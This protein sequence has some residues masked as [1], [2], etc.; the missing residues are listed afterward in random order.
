MLQKSTQEVTPVQRKF[1]FACR[2]GDFFNSVLSKGDMREKL[3]KAF[4]P[5]GNHL[6]G[7]VTSNAMTRFEA[8]MG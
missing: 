7:Y 2:K 1:L 8:E 4:R 6:P 5:D 3:F